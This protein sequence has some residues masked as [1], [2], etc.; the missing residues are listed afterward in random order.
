MECEFCRLAEQ[1]DKII[2]QDDDII[3]AVKD[4]GLSPGQITVFP[5]KHFTIMEMVPENILEKCGQIAN[6]ISIA[7][8]EGLGSQGTNIIVRNGTAAGQT[9]PHF[10]LEVIPRA[11]N[12]GLNLLWQPLQ[13]MEDEIES[14][15]KVLKEE[16]DKPE[17]KVEE[18]ADEEQAPKKENKDNYLLK[19]LKRIP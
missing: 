13:L 11:E 17:V 6:K 9:V 19:S 16:A 3:A 10:A 2:Y 15:F 5:K 1:E 8:F 7:V 12:D 4:T 14:S 18:K